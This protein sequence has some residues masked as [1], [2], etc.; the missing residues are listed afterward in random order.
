MHAAALTL[1][2]MFLLVEGRVR[3]PLI[4]LSQLRNGRFTT[5]I[6]ANGILHMTM[7][8]AV[9]SA[10]FLVQRGLGL[11]AVQTGI[12]LTTMK[13]CTTA[14][15][16]VGGWLYD[17]TRAWGLCPA[18]LVMIASGLTALGLIGDALDYPRAFALLVWMGIGSGCFMTTNNT[19][20]MGALA[21]EYRGFAS[22]LLETS[23]QYG[24][25]VGVAVAA[26]GLAA[27][28][29]VT[30]SAQIEAAATRAGFGQSAL[31][32]SAIAWAGVLLAAYPM[33]RLVV[34]APAL[35]SARAVPAIAESSA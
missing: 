25:T 31:I 17:R 22:G 23:R 1:L 13:A 30:G 19:R 29:L 9:F 18:A 27:A 10:P 26:T 5:A 15:T 34:S 4:P 7:M 6:G 12:L 16:L 24:H 8:V 14:M 33:K 20:I 2:V 21:A 3:A 35:G 28:A 11:G 32:A